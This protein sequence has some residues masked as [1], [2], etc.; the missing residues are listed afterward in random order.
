MK[1]KAKKVVKAV[2][3]K[4]RGR[5][6]GSKNKPKE[7]VTKGISDS[8]PADIKE[9]GIELVKKIL[10]HILELFKAS[11][12][13]AFKQYVESRINGSLPASIEEFI[14]KFKHSYKL[15]GITDHQLLSVL[16]EY[17]R[18]YVLNSTAA[19]PLQQP[20]GLAQV[21]APEPVNVS[22]SKPVVTVNCPVEPKPDDESVFDNL[23]LL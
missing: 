13:D 10:N 1:K 16:D 21:A 22:P 17:E 4:K 11:V 8:I 18:E 12:F 15:H 2:T 7:L 3:G 9:D 6:P 20:V 14:N 5:K 19:S 23:D